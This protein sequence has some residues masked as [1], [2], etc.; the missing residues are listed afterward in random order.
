MAVASGVEALPEAPTL[1]PSTLTPAEPLAPAEAVWFTSLVAVLP[2]PI[3][4]LSVRPAVLLAV[5]SVRLVAPPTAPVTGAVEGV[6]AEAPP[7]MLPD[8]PMPPAVPDAMPPADEPR[9]PTAPPP[10]PPKSWAEAGV[11]IKAAPLNSATANALRITVFMFL[12]F[13][14]ARGSAPYLFSP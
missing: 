9:P 14:G 13:G 4:V 6:I 11:T 2:A 8:A 7:L 12:S 5:F 10:W 1:L 3:A